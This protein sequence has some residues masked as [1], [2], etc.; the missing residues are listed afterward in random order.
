MVGWWT[1]LACG[2][3]GGEPSA[4]TTPLATTPPADPP[5]G[6]SSPAPPPPAPTLTTSHPTTAPIRFVA[7]GDAGEGNDAQYEV[8]AAMEVVCA[9]LGCDFALYLGDNF[10]DSGVDSVSDEQFVTKFESPYQGLL[11]PF[12]VVLGNHDLGLDGVGLKLWKGPIYVEYSALSSK[13]TMPAEYYSVQTGNLTLVALNTT[14][15]FFGLGD[16]Q[17]AWLDAT[18]AQVDPA[19]T[20]WTIAFGH[21]PYVSNG[22]HGNA[23]AYD[24]I[25]EWVPATEIPRGVY[26]EEVFAASVCG[27]VDLYISGHDH[28]RQWL[29]DTCGTTFVVSGA[30]AK[31]TPLEDRGNATLFE[32]DA[33]EGFLWV[34]LDGRTLTAR[35]FDRYGNEDYWLTYVK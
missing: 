28:N 5:V 33:T 14:E 26:V 31:L 7:L 11:F 8:A 24:D 22:A 12:Y 3:I 34:E 16:D 29:G 21:H 18:L 2:T 9:D 13:W 35:F 4:S 6:T 27:K 30:G 32:D 23:G 25:P 19:V 10:Y 20:D 1:W 17:Q 15:I